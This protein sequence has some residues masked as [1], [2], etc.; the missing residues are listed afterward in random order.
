MSEPLIQR[1]PLFGQSDIRATPPEGAH[2]FRPPLVKVGPML[3]S[4]TCV[5]CGV[6]AVNADTFCKG[7]PK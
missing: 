2:D 1:K 6:L 7:A 5:R 3:Y 4:Q